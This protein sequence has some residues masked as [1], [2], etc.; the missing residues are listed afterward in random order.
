MTTSTVESISSLYFFIPFSFGS[1]GHEAFM[2]STL[3]SLTKFF[4]LRNTGR[5]CLEAELGVWEKHGRRDLN[6][7]PA[8]LET[9]ALPIELLPFC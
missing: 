7:Q 3:T 4:T 6:P 8:V 1:Q 2:S 5:E 9:A